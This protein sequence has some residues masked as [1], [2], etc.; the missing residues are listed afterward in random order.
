MKNLLN[1]AMEY[2]GQFTQEQ[3]AWLAGAVI[4]VGYIFYN[5]KKYVELFDNAVVASETT[6]N[7]EGSQQKMDTAVAFVYKR[8]DTL[9]LPARIVLKKFI[10]KERI[11]T[12]LEKSL[13]KFSNVFGSGKKVDIKGNE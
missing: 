10:T 2:L 8:I 3:W 7:Q 13:Q 5:R 11:V 6:L 4:I 1:K 12:L 9:P